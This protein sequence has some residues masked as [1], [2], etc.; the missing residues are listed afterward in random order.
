MI[1]FFQKNIEPNKKLKTFEI[2]VLIL[3]IIGSIVSY[4]VGL[5]KVHSNIG[6]LQFVQSMQMTRDTELEDYDG[7]E[8]AMCDVTYRNGD[9]EL[10][11]TL[12]FEE[13][14]QLDSE[15]ITAYEFGSFG[16]VLS[17]GVRA[18]KA[19]FYKVFA[20]SYFL[21]GSVKNRHFL[22][23][24]CSKWCSKMLWEI[25]KVMEIRDRKR[26]KDLI[27]LKLLK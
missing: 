23:K 25:W 11:I 7:E 18:R 24:W 17:C 8:N 21:S 1:Q 12:P 4:G 10:V 27:K 26:N 15:T 14:E 3:L 22:K 13:Y 16:V 19:L 20:G 6:N 2:I 9:K 5:S